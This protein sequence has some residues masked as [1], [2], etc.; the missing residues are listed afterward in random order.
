MTC[1]DLED[2]ALEGEDLRC[3]LEDGLD[4]RGEL[5]RRSRQGEGRRRGLGGTVRKASGESAR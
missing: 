4:Q 5:K 3:G 2:Q 1:G